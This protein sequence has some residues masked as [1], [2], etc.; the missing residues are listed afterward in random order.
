MTKFLL[1]AGDDPYDAL[2]GWCDFI[3]AFETAEE[4]FARVLADA[5]HWWQV[6]DTNLLTEVDDPPGFEEQV[7]AAAGLK[8]AQCA[9]AI[10]EYEAR[11]KQAVADIQATVKAMRDREAAAQRQAFVDV[12][13]EETA[14]QIE[15]RLLTPRS[16][17]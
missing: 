6:V 13:G 4:A 8:K 10:A 2:G 3:A 11:R 9:V 17:R 16:E 15:A 12:V 1:F 14:A 7:S 5:P